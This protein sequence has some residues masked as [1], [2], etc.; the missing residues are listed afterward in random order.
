MS[1]FIVSDMLFCVVI[2][3]KSLLLIRNCY[4]HC[5]FWLLCNCCFLLFEPIFCVV[6]I[7]QHVVQG[8][9]C[10]IQIDHLYT[11]VI[12]VLAVAFFGAYW[13]FPVECIGLQQHLTFIVVQIF[14]MTFLIVAFIS[15]VS[16]DANA[17]Q[18]FV[19]HNSQ[20]CFIFLLSFF[21]TYWDFSIPLS[22]NYGSLVFSPNT[23]ILF[24]ICLIIS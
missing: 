10:Y 24:F 5:M 22:Y 16:V 1:G 13:Y 19:L 3:N 23:Y 18:F 9:W 7:L 4:K 2:H 11:I 21:V 12:I 15:I 17:V 14:Y 20:F 6:N 8:Q